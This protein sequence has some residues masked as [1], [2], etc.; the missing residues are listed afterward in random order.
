MP[1]VKPN[2]KTSKHF[3]KFANKGKRDNLAIFLKEYRRVAALIVDDIWLNGY[4]STVKGVDYEFNVSKNLFQVPKYIDYN[5]FKFD[6]TL[7]ARA[8]SSLVTQLVAVLGAAVDKQ[9]K[10]VWQLNKSKEEGVSKRKRHLLARKIKTNIP[11]KPTVVKLNPELSSKCI[12]WQ[13]TDC[14]FNGFIRLKSIMTNKMQIKIPI[15]YHKHSHKLVQL[16]GEKMTS[17]IISDDYVNIRWTLPKVEQKKEG[18]VVGADQGFKDVLTL[19]DE[20]VTPRSDI[21]GHSLESILRTMSRKKKGSKAF[22]RSQAH[23]KNFINWS[24]KQLNFNGVKELRLEKIWNIGY[25]NK[26]SRLMSSWTNTIIKDKVEDRCVQEGVLLIEQSSTYRSQRCSGC[27]NVRKANR[28][29]KSY[30]CKNC[31]LTIDA[32]LNASLNHV[33]DLPEIPYTLRKQNLNR[34]GGFFWNP[35]GIYDF[36]GRSLESLPH[37][38][39]KTN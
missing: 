19:S 22:A 21:H 27:G 6:T 10:R 8:M 39:G 34:G 23:R 31:G 20:Q 7:T 38:E 14:Q 26:T 9:R 3:V 11:Q 25:K 2:I 16:G 28:K 13:S 12:D 37:V 5:R 35:V 33:V 18:D 15:K 36:E 1:K 30:S 29:G 24:V 32:D 17:F 4:K